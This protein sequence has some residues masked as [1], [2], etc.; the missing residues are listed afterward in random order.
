MKLKY[1]FTLGILAIALT[2]CNLPGSTSSTEISVPPTVQIRT[3]VPVV[4][5]VTATVTATPLP[6]PT[7][8]PIPTAIATEF[9]P[10][11]VKAGVDNFNVRTN[12]GYLFPVMTMVQQG[13]DLAVYGQA[14]GGEWI[15]IKTATGIYGWVFT[16]LI[17][18]EPRLAEAPVKEPEKVQL[19][20]G[21]LKD[22]QGNPISGFQFAMV[23]GSGQNAP[24]NDAMTD[25]NGEF[26]A[27]MPI[28][29]S[30]DWTVSYVAYACTSNVVNA[31]CNFLPGQNK[32]PSPLVMNITLPLNDP[33]QFTFQ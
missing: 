1:F 6:Q 25:V 27:Y 26:F 14:P 11:N 3:E 24:R 18:D 20:H 4:V 30:G 19:V 13:T 21:F 2:A 16:K 12:P 32:S 15:Y 31:D 23:Q 5:E 28:N 10:F 8:T 9:A 17:F 29:S 22:N 7:E 33:L